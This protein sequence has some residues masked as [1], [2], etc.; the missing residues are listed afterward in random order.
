MDIFQLALNGFLLAAQARLID[1]MHED[2]AQF[3]LDQIK[4]VTIAIDGRIPA[5]EWAS[6]DKA[7]RFGPAFW[8]E[9]PQKVVDLPLHVR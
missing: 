4:D 7:L 8:G 6:L 2:R 3:L 5:S 1:G 9:A